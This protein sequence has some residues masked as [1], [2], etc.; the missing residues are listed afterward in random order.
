MPYES[1]AEYLT[2]A[3]LYLAEA[4]PTLPVKQMGNGPRYLRMPSL[5]DRECNQCGLTKWEFTGNDLDV[6]ERWLTDFQY[7]CRNCEQSHFN[8]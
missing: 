8:V 1:L 4:F 2:N 7:K 5:L 3:P 6:H